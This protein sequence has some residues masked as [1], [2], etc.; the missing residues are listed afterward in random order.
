[1]PT[2]TPRISDVSDACI[3]PQA[4]WCMLQLMLRLYLPML[5]NVHQS[6]K[7]H[8]CIK[9]LDSFTVFNP[10]TVSNLVFLHCC[11]LVV[12]QNMLKSVKQLSIAIVSSDSTYMH[13]MSTPSCTCQNVHAI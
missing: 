8:F 9:K 5:D 7:L 11:L 1:M 12:V 4:Q 2:D 6:M 3:T 13:C 10:C